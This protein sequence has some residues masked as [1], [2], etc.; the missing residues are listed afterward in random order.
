MPKQD[1]GRQGE[2]LAQRYLKKKGYRHLASNYTT[3]QGE[4]D[5]VM[6]AGDTLVFVEVKT[7]TDEDYVPPEHVVNYGKRKRIAAAIRHFLHAQNVYDHPCRFDIVAVIIT[8]TNKPIIR[9][10]ENACSLF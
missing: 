9:H 6:Q 7:R 5:L 8:G 1:L 10:Q 4:I 2:K 3:R